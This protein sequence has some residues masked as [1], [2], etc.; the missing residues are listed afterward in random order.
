MDEI[1]E[2]LI[3]NFDQTGIHYIPVSDWT[4][5]EEGS[6]RVEIVG[7]GD[8]GSLQQFLRVR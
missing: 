2:D 1:P 3:I 7:K 6:K 4:M 5:A 8:K